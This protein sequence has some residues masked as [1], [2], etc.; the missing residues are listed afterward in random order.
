MSE[1]LADPASVVI[2]RRVQWPDTDA[3][4]HQHH[5]VVL[6]WVEEAELALLDGLG[7]ADLFGRTPRV[8]YRADYRARLWLGQ[9]VDITLAVARI[10]TSSLTY[11]YDVDSDK[12]SVASG[13][14]TI[15]HTGSNATGAQPWPEAIRAVLGGGGEQPHECL[16]RDSCRY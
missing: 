2:E 3:A 1:E 15:V 8:N 14:I 6:R 11:Q 9:R 12:K 16:V 10:G 5:S 4:G 13:E 7:L